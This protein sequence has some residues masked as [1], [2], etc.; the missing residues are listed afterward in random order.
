MLMGIREVFHFEL[1][2]AFSCGSTEEEKTK[3]S[4]LINGMGKKVRSFLQYLIVNHTRS[5][6]SEELIDQFWADNSR[7]PANALRNMLFKARQLLR[8]MFPEGEDMLLTL[9][10]CYSWNPAIRLSLDVE[11]FEELCVR[12]REEAEEERCSLLRQAVA[13]YGGEFLAGNDAE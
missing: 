5:V 11:E 2:G 10:D 13:L 6:S 1:L 4:E 3:N 9:Q 8:E 7:N 12:A